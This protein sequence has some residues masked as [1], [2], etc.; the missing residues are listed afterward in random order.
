MRLSSITFS[1]VILFLLLN[2]CTAGA[3]WTMQA[4][5]TTERL[6]GVS[7]VSQTAAWA[8]GNYGT[9][10]RTTDGGI[11]WQRAKVPEADSLDF[12]DV[13]AFD[14][15]T[16]YLLSIGTG[17]QSRIYKTHDGGRH[18][19]LQFTNSNANAFFDAMAFWD[20]NHGI[21][22]SDPVDGHFLLVRTSDGGK[23]WQEVPATNLPAA[24]PNEAAFAASGT[25]LTVQGNQ[26]VW[27]AT[28]GGAARVFRSAD[29]GV[30]WSVA[31]TPIRS[32]NASSGIFSIAFKDDKNGVIVGG[33][34]RKENVAS[35]HV[36]TTTD[37][38]RT[39]KLVESKLPK[40]FRSGVVYVTG[41][42]S[43]TLIAVG[44]SGS[45]YSLDNGLSWESIDT[46]GFHAVSFAGATNAGW[47]VGENGRIAKYMG[48]QPQVE[49]R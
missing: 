15:D 6:R 30:T 5:G 35:K 33:D 21:A 44:P 42:A 11:T 40:G 32:D 26:H 19:T 41:L 31:S 38:G 28:G 2:V 46:N 43:S 7:A 24:L 29:R 14:A 17:A 27:F 16:A 12:R 8:S 25:C 13:E 45:D 9:C 18:W 23:T 37:G 20:W 49:K 1:F 4:S 3:Q 34:F 22:L 36:A 48:S 47:A 39:W 10:V